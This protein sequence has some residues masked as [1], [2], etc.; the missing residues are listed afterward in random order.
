M[1]R[2]SLVDEAGVLETGAPEESATETVADVPA[3]SALGQVDV[4]GVDFDDALEAPCTMCP[5]LLT[6]GGV[7]VLLACI[8]ECVWCVALRLRLDTAFARLQTECVRGF[9]DRVRVWVLEGVQ[10]A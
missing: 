7:V 8:C 3:S 1:V 9:L 6:D 5:C 10:F 4:L 2:F